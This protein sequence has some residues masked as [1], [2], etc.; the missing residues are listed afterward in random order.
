[1]TIKV[2]LHVHSKYSEHPSQWLLQRLGTKESYTEPIQ[3]YE[4]A[5]K[6]GMTYVT[7]TDH[8]KFEKILYNF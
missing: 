7:I 6:N 2:D 4:L 3:I 1:M 5:K 8:N